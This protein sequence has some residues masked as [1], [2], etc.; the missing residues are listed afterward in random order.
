MANGKVSDTYLKPMNYVLMGDI[1]SVFSQFE[2]AV[3]FIQ[4]NI[5]NYHLILLGDVFDSRCSESNSVAVYKLI[6]ELQEAGNATLVH[7]NHQWKLQRYLRGNPV[8]IHSLQRTLDDFEQSDVSNEELLNW[9]ETLPFALSFKDANDQEYRCSHA[10]HSSKLYVPQ[11][12]EGIYK[13]HEVSGKMRD[14]L[15]YGALNSEGQRVY[16]WEN[17]SR[18]QWIRCAGHYHNVTVSYDNRSIVLDSCCG[19]EDG[20]LSIYDVN[21]RSLYQF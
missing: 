20:L 8:K 16:W 14:K 13:V 9:L 19:N 11:R 18:K 21:S 17:E 15:I 12:Y 4:N 5:Q 6:R 2:R 1:H 10:Y 7:S 3:S